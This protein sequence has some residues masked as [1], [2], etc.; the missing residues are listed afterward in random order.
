VRAVGVDTGGSNI[1]FARH[2]ESGEV[3]VIEMNPRVSRSSALA[4]KA[5]GYPIAKVAARLAVGYTLDEIPNDLT[6]TTPASFEP[7][8]DYVVV[9]FPRFAFE[10]FPGADRTLGTQMKS[11]GETMGIGRTFAEAF[12]KSYRS[13]ELDAG[14]ATPWQALG[15]V[16]EDVHPFFQ[17]ELAEIRGALDALGDVDALVAGDWLWLKRLGLSDADIAAAAGSTETTVR[18]RRRDCGVRPAY[19]RGDSCAGAVAAASD[20][21]YSPLGQ[22]AAP[23]SGG[24][25]A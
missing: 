23:V 17:L 20:S 8:L 13:R 9:K 5:T 22:A 2:R 12:L 10:K 4:S 18:Q 15:E 3:R 11:V 24:A 21:Y 16:P 19:R 14:A 7:T 6:G 25:R 1:Q